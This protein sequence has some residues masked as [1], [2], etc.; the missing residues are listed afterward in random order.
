[1]KCQYCGTEM[2]TAG[3]LKCGFNGYGFKYQAPSL[4]NWGP[5]VC[6]G[7]LL[8]ITIFVDDEVS[9]TILLERLRANME[10]SE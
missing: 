8:G 3:C 6:V 2:G 1:M 7:R 5:K 4:I 9:K 10:I